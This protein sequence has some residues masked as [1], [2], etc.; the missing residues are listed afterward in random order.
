MADETRMTNAAVVE[1][2][3]SRDPSMQKR[4]QDQVN[5]VIQTK[6]RED[7]IMRGP[8]LGAE[9]VGMD[10]LDTQVDVEAPTKIFEK[11]PY[12]PAAVT[13]PFGHEANALEITGN[14]GLVIFH[15]ITT[16]RHRKD[17][18][19]LAT[20][21]NDVRQ[22]IT[23]QDVKEILEEEDL[24]SFALIDD[25]LGGAPGTP[26]P[27]ADDNVLWKSI[28]GTLTPQTWV[29]AMQILMDTPARFRPATVVINQ[30]LAENLVAWDS[31]ELSPDILEEVNRRGW[32]QTTFKGRNLVITIKSN[33]VANN[34]M[35][36][37]AEPNQ[38]GRFWILEDVTMYPKAEGSILEWWS[39]E[40]IGIT[41]QPIG[42]AKVTLEGV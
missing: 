30:H 16:K 36:M 14:R 13:V 25:M 17:K 34:E 22:L 24:T 7:G 31:D 19:L 35:Y 41:L 9:T 23:D 21:K 4:A 11:E 28:A 6:A 8:V 20:F 12:I 15:K 33:V 1:S 29:D 38:L 42:C 32:V 2:L 26:V 27:M 37:F 5:D 10:E 18:H 39:E 3:F 40:V